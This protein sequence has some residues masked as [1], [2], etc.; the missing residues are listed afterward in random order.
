MQN[1]K[2]TFE[3]LTKRHG[4]MYAMQILG[5][6][7]EMAYAEERKKTLLSTPADRFV[8][9]MTRLMIDQTAADA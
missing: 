2:L 6:L 3:V 4:P 9:V 8:E 7:E 5:V 1:T